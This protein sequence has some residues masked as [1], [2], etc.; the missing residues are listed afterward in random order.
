[1]WTP[2]P[3][4]FT[5][6]APLTIVVEIF[7]APNVFVEILVSVTETFRKITLAIAYPLVNRITWSS[8]EQVPIAGALARSDE[9]RGASIAQREPGGV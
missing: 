8:G 5:G 2:D 3:A 7:G 4:V 9:F 6:V 1:V